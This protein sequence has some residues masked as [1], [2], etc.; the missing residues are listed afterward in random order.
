MDMKTS[1][2]SGIEVTKDMTDYDASCKR[3]LSEK[4]IL[5][6]IM[7]SCLDEFRNFDVKTIA[8]E[9][10]EGNPLVSEVPV[11]PDETG[12]VIQGNAQEHTSPTEG[13]IDFD[14]CFNAIVPGTEE[15]VS[16]IINVEA[17]DDFYPGYSLL[18]RGIFY[19]GR[20]ISAQAGSVF[21]HSQYDKLRKVFSIWICTNPPKFRAGTINRY[22]LY[23]EHLI[24]ENQEDPQKYDMLSIVMVYLDN[25]SKD[26]GNGLLKML[27][28]LLSPD[29]KPDEKKHILQDD[30]HIP[31]MQNTETE[32]SHM[33]NLGLGL[34]RKAME[35]GL[36]QGLQQ[37]LREGEENGLLT[38][39]KNL[40]ASMNLTAEEAMQA[41]RIPE[42]E[43]QKYLAKLAQ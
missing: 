30:F 16:L 8:E 12:P 14:I 19:C 13:S 40:M 42:E 33:S 34:A 28:V 43:K 3:L 25:A 18:K 36:Q 37:G 11:A 22:R 31:M 29:V 15:N 5:A 24:G 26:N 21:Y 23:E 7:K 20:L 2:S 38:A 1:L 10:I 6:W 39:L 41:L 32:V 4:I 17:Q 27:S 9:C 35:E